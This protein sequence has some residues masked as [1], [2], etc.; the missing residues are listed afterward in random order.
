MYI[1]R[2]THKATASGRADGQKGPIMS[3]EATRTAIIETGAGLY[4]LDVTFSA[5][6]DLDGTF[7]ATCNDTGEI[8]RINGW[9]IDSIDYT[10]G[11]E[12]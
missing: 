4:S 11:V 2:Y 7:E 1:K 10:D 9:L 3:N 12:G 8:L 5:D 6:A